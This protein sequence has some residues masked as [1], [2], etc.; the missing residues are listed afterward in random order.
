MQI[1]LISDIHGNRVALNA[2][3][4]DLPSALDETICLGDIVGY[5]PWPQACLELVREH[6]SIC[7]QGNH[8]R[9]VRSPAG[10]TN[11]DQAMAGLWYAQDALTDDELAW[12]GS[13]PR[14]TTA[15]DD[16][17][18]LAHDHPEKVDRYVTPSAFAGVRPYLDEFEACFLG[19]THIQHEAVIDGRLILNPGS[20]GQ[21]RDGDPRAAYAVVDTDTWETSLH[22]VA[23]D[24]GR[25]QDTVAEQGLPSEIGDRL[26]SGR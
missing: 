5:G 6:C 3:L 15:V 25:V 26:A 19:H 17:L 14:R 16:S 11:N 8:D 2:V 12:L 23:Y 18:L 4:E 24:I 9:E 20:V 7:L 10:Y 1:G 22:R 21:P 13:L